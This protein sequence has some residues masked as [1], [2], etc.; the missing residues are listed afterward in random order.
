[1]AKKSTRYKKKARGSA[2]KVG[3]PLRPIGA[4]YNRQEP[5]FLGRDYAATSFQAL[6]TMNKYNHAVEGYE[7]FKKYSGRMDELERQISQAQ[8]VNPVVSGRLQNLQTGLDLVSRTQQRI[9]SAQNTL[10]ADH[11]Q[12][13]REAQEREILMQ[14]GFESQINNLQRQRSRRPTT[15]PPPS[16]SQVSPPASR[17]A[18]P[19]PASRPRHRPTTPPPTSPS[20]E[21]PQSRGGTQTARSDARTQ[22]RIPKPQK[23]SG[24]GVK[25]ND[26]ILSARSE[27]AQFLPR[28]KG[29]AAAAARQERENFGAGGATTQSP[30][31]T[32]RAAAGLKSGARRVVSTIKTLD[33]GN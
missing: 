14:A 21:A 19:P 6:H 26:Q 30:R 33:G 3:R 29:R 15:P 10:R 22:S 11:I 20:R 13:K 17:S 32:A 24:T 25:T 12:S 5:Y 1:M 8:G 31:A 18:S 23:R 28:Q 27:Q 9:S 7:Q 4:P 16:P 2:R